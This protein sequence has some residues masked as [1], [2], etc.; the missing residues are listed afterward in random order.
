MRDLKHLTKP[1]RH[2]F[3]QHWKT[4]LISCSLVLLLIP[5]TILLVRKG[6]QA[7]SSWQTARHQSKPTVKS[8]PL[9]DQLFSVADGLLPTATDREGR[10]TA[11][12]ADGT[13][14][15]YSI[16]PVLQRQVRSYLEAT[17]PA[18]AVLV[19]IEPATGRVLSLAG[20]STL[21]PAWQ[22]TAAYQVY[23]MASLFK[24]VTA[25]AALENRKITP[26]TVI[27]F[28]GRL[29]SETPKNWDPRPRGRNIEMDLTSAMAKS[30]NPVYGLIASDLLGREQLQRACN[31]FGFNRS[32]LLPGVPAVPSAAPLP[33]SVNDLRL[34]GCGL[35][36]ELKVSPIHAAAI[37]AAI[38]NRGSLMAP[39]L[40]DQASRDGK[41]LPVPSP[42]E[43]ERV[44]SPDTANSLTRMLLTT[45]TSGTS[46]RAFR[47]GEGRKLVREM[48]IAAKTGSID[49]DNPKGHYSWF[50]AYAPAD[51]PRIALVALVI[52]GDK[53]RIKASN[54]GEQALATF[55]KQGT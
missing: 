54:L 13:I 34:Q 22:Q 44:I 28:R 42:R 23:P 35:D 53:W 41:P 15:S 20:Y 31:R 8:T 19:A 5:A 9:G 49:G 2:P 24:M 55:F 33:E 43:L 45:V 10:L 36:H 26:E 32:L 3:L 40:V 12:A 46:R 51:R 25:A 29:V 30:V 37:T 27:A 14:I 4:I 6:A 21:D 39:R 18:Y 50:A 7:V 47:S 11:T 38:A 48:Q 16:N 17:R 52:N 1:N